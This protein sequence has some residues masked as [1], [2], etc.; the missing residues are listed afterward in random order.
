M[1]TLIAFVLLTSTAH[2]ELLGWFAWNNPRPET[3][4][5]WEVS[6]FPVFYTTGFP[7]YK[8]VTE[9]GGYWVTPG[10]ATL[11]DSPTLD[12]FEQ[13]WTSPDGRYGGINMVN[14]DDHWGT[15][16]YSG[17][18]LGYL[19]SLDGAT[20]SLGPGDLGA[21]NGSV[22][23]Q[24]L[25]PRKGNLLYGYDF[26]HLERIVTPTSQRIEIY[27][28]AI[29]VPE[30]ATWVLVVAMLCMGARLPPSPN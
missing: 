16:G 10:N 2:A 4:A 7:D 17:V 9:L 15:R 11:G 24:T 12:L 25:V 1:R 18:S 8:F 5:R 30:P 29:A 19:L 22:S 13:W 20:V 14:G 21:D 27:G 6:S 28:A 23:G 3:T 26:T